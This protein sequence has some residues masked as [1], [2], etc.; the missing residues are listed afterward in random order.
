MG[1]GVPQVLN[2]WSTRH[3][4]INTK[5]GTK[6]APLARISVGQGS[7]CGPDSVWGKIQCVGLVVRQDSVCGPLCWT[8]MVYL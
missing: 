5:M 6:L 2:L 3:R 8:N 7:V 1:L 4:P